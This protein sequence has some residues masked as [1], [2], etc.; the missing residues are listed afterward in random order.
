MIKRVKDGIIKYSEFEKVIEHF[1]MPDDKTAIVVGK[2]NSNT[3]QKML[4]ELMQA[5]NMKEELQKFGFY[6]E[7]KW[8]KL[9]RHARYFRNRTTANKG[10]AKVGAGPTNLQLQFTYRLLMFGLDNL[11]QQLCAT[12]NLVKFS[13]SSGRTVGKFPTSL[14]PGTL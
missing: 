3:N 6:R 11:L 5:N 9:I 10:L 14:S 1:T 4:T 2:E 12:Q 8:Q 13:F 7:G